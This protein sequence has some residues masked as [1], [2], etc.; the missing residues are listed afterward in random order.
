LKDLA[1]VTTSELGALSMDWNQHCSL[2]IGVFVA[3]LLAT[4][5]GNF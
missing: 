2:F 5:A 3:A 1:Y 4:G